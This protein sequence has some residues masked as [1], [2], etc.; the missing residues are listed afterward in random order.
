MNGSTAVN[1]LAFVPADVTAPAMVEV[2]AGRLDQV[3]VARAWSRA[4]MQGLPASLDDAVLIVTELFANAA[5][6]TRSGLPGGQVLV[7]VAGGVIHVHDQGTAGMTRPAGLP[8]GP[9]D[10]MMRESGRG[11]L[12]VAALSAEWGCGRCPEPGAPTFAGCCFWSRPWPT[13]A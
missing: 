11:L 1:E 13:S 3:P 4:Q 8:A 5:R 12:L 9:H 10:D 2:F 7:A 6:H